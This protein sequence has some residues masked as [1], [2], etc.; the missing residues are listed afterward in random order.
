MKKRLIQWVLQLRH[1]ELWE[2]D[3]RYENNDEIMIITTAC[4]KAC[5][6]HT[7]M[8]LR[9]GTVQGSSQFATVFLNYQEKK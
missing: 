5:T 3:K 7:C 6:L 2:R 4:G 8:I 9:S 1:C